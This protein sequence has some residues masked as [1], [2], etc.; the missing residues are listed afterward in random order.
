MKA[1]KIPYTNII[2]HKDIAPGRKS[3]IA[4]SFWISKYPKFFDYKKANFENI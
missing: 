4:D 2:R 3:D 1:Y